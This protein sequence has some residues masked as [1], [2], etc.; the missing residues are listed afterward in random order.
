M[1]MVGMSSAAIMTNHPSRPCS[2]LPALNHSSTRTANALTAPYTRL[3]ARNGCSC[4]ISKAKRIERKVM[5]KPYRSINRYES[6]PDVTITQC[7]SGIKPADIPAL[8][9]TAKNASCAQQM[10]EIAQ[11][12]HNGPPNEEVFI[13]HCIKRA[14]PHFVVREFHGAPLKKQTNQQ[15]SKRHLENFSHFARISAQ[16]ER[17]LN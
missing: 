4:S 8:H 10:E 9:R 15:K 2:A 16:V 1:S 5:K 14:A 17:R 11:H 7:P 13:R 12:T 6:L 3:S